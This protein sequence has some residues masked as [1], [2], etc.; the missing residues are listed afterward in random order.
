MV[1][2]SSSKCKVT[3][4]VTFTWSHQLT[5]EALGLNQCTLHNFV[6]SSDY[7]IFSP[8]ICR[9]WKRMLGWD[10]IYLLQNNVSQLLFLCRSCCLVKETI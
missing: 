2:Q 10:D 8:L 3:K 4:F 7:L 5:C 6:S 1:C 9:C